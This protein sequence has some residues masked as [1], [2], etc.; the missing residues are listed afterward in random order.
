M[1][2]AR[3]WLS[4]PRKYKKGSVENQEIGSTAIGA[5][6]NEYF[7]SGDMEYSSMTSKTSLRVKPC[8][9]S[10]ITSSSN[11]EASLSPC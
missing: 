5:R 9:A 7:Q 10:K 2:L 8:H 11:M 1:R 4:Y 6:L 3:D